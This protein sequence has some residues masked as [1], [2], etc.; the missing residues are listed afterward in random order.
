MNLFL[1]FACFLFFYCVY[2]S[3]IEISYEIIAK[4]KKRTNYDNQFKQ[5]YIARNNRKRHRS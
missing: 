2:L 3:V 5:G 1:Y 4:L